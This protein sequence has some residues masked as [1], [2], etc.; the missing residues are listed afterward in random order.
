M[1]DFNMTFETDNTFNMSFDGDNDFNAGFENVQ[2]VETGDYE[3]LSNKPRIEEVILIG[4]KTF[5][6]L[7]LESMTVQEVQA[8]LYNNPKRRRKNG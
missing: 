5:K 3:K 4:N 7:G 8:I 2:V 1:A 6:Q